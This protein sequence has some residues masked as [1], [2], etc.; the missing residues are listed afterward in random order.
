MGVSRKLKQLNPA[1]QIVGVEPY[2]GHKIQGLKNLK[3]AYCPE[4]FE[5]Q[6]LDKKINILVREKSMDAEGAAKILNAFRSIDA[7]LGLLEFDKNADDATI[8]ELIKNRNSARLTQDWE[9]ADRIRDQLRAR[10]ISV[11]DQRL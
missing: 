8:Q 11:Q 7:V 10:G 9:H 3:E 4:I 5:K 1:V 6:R 2:L